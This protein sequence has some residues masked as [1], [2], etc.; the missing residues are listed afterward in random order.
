M[1]ESTLILFLVQ[2]WGQYRAETNEIV[3]IN[4]VLE[5]AVNSRQFA[6]ESGQLAAQ[7]QYIYSVINKNRKPATV[8]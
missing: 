5:F 8:Q 3:G 1:G 6:V 4:V 7:C 2:K